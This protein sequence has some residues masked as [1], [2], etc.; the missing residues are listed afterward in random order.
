MACGAQRRAASRK[1]LL[2]P[3]PEYETRWQGGGQWSH[4]TGQ[5]APGSTEAGRRPVL[6]QRPHGGSPLSPV[7][8]EGP[9]RRQAAPGAHTQSGGPVR[10][11]PAGEFAQHRC[12]GTGWATLLRHGRAPAS[13][14]APLGSPAPSEAGRVCPSPV[15]GA[16]TADEAPARGPPSELG[17]LRVLSVPG[18]RAVP[19][20]PVRTPCL[21]PTSDETALHPWWTRR[22]NALTSEGF[23][24]PA[25]GRLQYGPYTAESIP[26]PQVRPALKTHH[27]QDLAG[28]PSSGREGVSRH[29]TVCKGGPRSVS[30][31][32]PKRLRRGSL[33]CA[34]LS[35]KEKRELGKP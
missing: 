12:R 27:W 6:W 23:S 9:Q 10:L 4:P 30:S 20:A 11:R 25:K 3:V 14:R 21:E 29:G 31:L 2:S 8:R 1:P 34:F 13:P 5:A 26:R 7:D 24:H 16:G 18:A 28:T 35:H 33:V 17:P 15:P 19:A 22:D 32:S